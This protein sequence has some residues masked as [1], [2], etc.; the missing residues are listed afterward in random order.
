MENKS[1]FYKLIDGEWWY[2][3]NAVYGPNFTLLKENKDD[4]NYPV[5]GWVW[6]DEQPSLN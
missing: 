5:D 2:A 6:F 4:Y 1:G 3:P